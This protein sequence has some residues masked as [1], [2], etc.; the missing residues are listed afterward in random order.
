MRPERTN[1][2]RHLGNKNPGNQKS[3]SGSHCWDGYLVSISCPSA[4]E[5]YSRQV[6]QVVLAWHPG[7][8]LNS[9]NVGPRLQLHWT[10]VNEKKI[11]KGI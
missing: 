10:G 1:G 5:S 6:D 11:L 9:G 3:M 2:F 4:Q 8:P 7:R